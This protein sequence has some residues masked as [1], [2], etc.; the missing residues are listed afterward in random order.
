[1]SLH[2]LRHQEEQRFARCEHL[3]DV[4]TEIHP[5]AN[6]L[7]T[8]LRLMRLMS[9]DDLKFAAQQVAEFLDNDRDDFK[10][11]I[12]K[13]VPIELLIEYIGAPHN[14][15][16]QT[17]EARQTIFNRLSDKLPAS[18]NIL[19]RTFYGLSYAAYT[20][21]F[22]AVGVRALTIS[23]PS[24]PVNQGLTSAMEWLPQ[25]MRALGVPG[26]LA[27]QNNPQLAEVS[28]GILC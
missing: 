4:M 14:A 21:A 27:V 16:T 9:S 19:R 13:E 7:Q 26:A 23:N 5:L 3:M 22:Y 25:G 28:A 24:D 17:M 11:L 10:I 15:T 6:R 8:K 2:D 12:E 20:A 18:D 1:M